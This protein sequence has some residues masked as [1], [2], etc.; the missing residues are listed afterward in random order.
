MASGVEHD[1]VAAGVGFRSQTG[2]R[3]LLVYPSYFSVLQ[4]HRQIK[5][6]EVEV[7]DVYDVSLSRMQYFKFKLE[8]LQ[9]LSGSNKVF[10][11]PYSTVSSFPLPLQACDQPDA[12]EPRLLPAA[13]PRCGSGPISGSWGDGGKW[14]RRR[15]RGRAAGN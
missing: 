13:L 3:V 8:L 9:S 7:E 11:R 14:R 15:G 2:G 10:S 6:E 5:K 4:P 1:K 12:F